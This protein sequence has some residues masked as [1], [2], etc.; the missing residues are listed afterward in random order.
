MNYSL[1]QDIETKIGQL[2]PGEKQILLDRLG[3]DLRSHTGTKQE[4]AA[5]LA[6]MA[7]DSDIQREIREIEREF[8]EAAE[9]GLEDL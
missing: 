5:T 3:H 9:D 2:S 8:A 6:I 4:F 7:D 1:L